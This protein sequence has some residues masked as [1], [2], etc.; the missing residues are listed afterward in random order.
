MDLRWDDLRYLEAI[1]R[2]GKVSAAARD[3]GI[4]SSTLYRRVAELESR[5]D[6]VCLHRG[7]SGGTLT[8]V[9]E[10]LAEIG[11]RT[12]DGLSTVE[13]RLRAEATGVSG[14]VRLTTVQALLPFVEA[15]LAEL[16]TTHPELHVTLH[17]GDDGPSVRAREADVALAVM[18]R[19]PEGCWG[20]RVT[21]LR[22]GVY[23]TRAAAARKPRRWLLRAMAEQS[24]PEAAWERKHAGDV[25]VRAPF[26]ALVSLCARGAGL[27][28]LPTLLASRHRGLVEVADAPS[29]QGL[30]RPIWLLT[31]PDL[32]KTPRI[33]AVLDAL[34]RPFD[35][36]SVAS[37]G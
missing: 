25:A 15:P 35:E 10:E 26:D 13:G 3:L 14:E 30:D 20:R 32:R 36:E 9:G 16:T 7:P 19:P 27:A 17:L 34:A 23:A 8:P 12:R 33:L 6:R 21:K 29:T 37:P 5:L 28:L 18:K 4:G 31:H 11:R 2:C 24:A 1:Q 22:Y